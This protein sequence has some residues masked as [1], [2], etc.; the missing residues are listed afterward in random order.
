MLLQAAH[1]RIPFLPLP[2]LI[3]RNQLTNLAQHS[4]K[5]ISQHTDL[6]GT[7]TPAARIEI[8]RFGS[9]HIRHQS[10]YRLGNRT[11]EPQ[12]RTQTKQTH[13]KDKTDHVKLNLP[14]LGYG[15]FGREYPHR[16]PARKGR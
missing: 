13:H 10:E 12:R 15:F 16:S 6:I 5:T 2:Q 7:I 8:A 9:A 14:H 3:Q 4:I 11:G 1:L